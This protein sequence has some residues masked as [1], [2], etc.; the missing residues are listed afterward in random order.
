MLQKE[1][2]EWFSVQ[3]AYNF[4]CFEID[5]WK[6]LVGFGPMRQFYQILE[7]RE[8]V[9]DILLDKTPPNILFYYVC[10]IELTKATKFMG[11]VKNSSSLLY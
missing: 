6:R 5:N 2:K 7:I 4:N 10:F 8:E 9:K 11:Q 3:L 1:K